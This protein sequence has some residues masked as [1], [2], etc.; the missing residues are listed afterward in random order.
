MSGQA[1]EEAL[2]KQKEELEKISEE[3][4][5]HFREAF[6][7]YD[8]DGS[9]TISTNE[10]GRIMEALGQNPTEE[11]IRDM[12][13]EVDMNRNG[14]ID[15]DEFCLL[16]AKQKANIKEGEEYRKAFKVFDKFNNDAI[17]PSEFKHVMEMFGEKL[18]DDEITEMI[19]FATRG[20]KGQINYEEFYA[21]MTMNF[22]NYTG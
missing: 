13:E 14:E 7:I 6:N 15:F 11:E 10:L 22:D 12:I 17:G 3:D 20:Q 4:K 2:R 8:K 19:K 21:M 18:E 1:T 9:G 5:V 16:M